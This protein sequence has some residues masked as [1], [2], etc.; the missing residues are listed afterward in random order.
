VQFSTGLPYCRPELFVATKEMD[1]D[2]T[3]GGEQTGSGDN[4]PEAGLE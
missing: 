4:T 3:D 1:T 2:V